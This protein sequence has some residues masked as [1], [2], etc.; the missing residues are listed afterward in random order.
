MAPYRA[1]LS[2]EHAEIDHGVEQHE[3]EDEKAFSPKHESKTRLRRCGLIDG[4][5]EGNDVRPERD[6]QRA[7][8]CKEDQDDHGKGE[9]VAAVANTE[10]EHD[11]RKRADHWE[12]EQIWT[13]Q[14]SAYHP[15]IFAE[16]IG[17]HDNKKCEQADRQ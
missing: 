15:K 8:G 10:C 9:I 1:D 12:D 14:P 11:D 2:S 16:R 7:K 17:K 4:E 3:R 6:R 13:L 5:D